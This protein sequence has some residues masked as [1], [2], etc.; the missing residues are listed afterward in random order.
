MGTGHSAGVGDRVF[1]WVFPAASHVRGLCSHTDVTAQARAH[2]FHSGKSSSNPGYG[3]TETEFPCFSLESRQQLSA[4]QEA[5]TPLGVRE[6]L[7]HKAATH[8]GK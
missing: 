8:Q 3:T 1:L 2:C 6:E 4:L 7:R 5:V